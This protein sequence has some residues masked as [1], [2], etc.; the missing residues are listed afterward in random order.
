VSANLKRLI[1]IACCAFSKTAAAQEL[2]RLPTQPSCPTCTIILESITILDPTG[3]LRWE[4]SI[5][6]LRDGRYVA[7]PTWTPGRIAVFSPSGRHTE[8]FGRVGE[9]PGEFRGIIGLYTTPAGN[10]LVI[11]EVLERL[12][13]SWS[14]IGLREHSSL[15]PT[16]RSGRFSN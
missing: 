5:A 2:I 4:A 3:E 13:I 9:G 6:E 11:D 8:T 15:H 14:D 10:V 16:A 12:S 1:A 7:A